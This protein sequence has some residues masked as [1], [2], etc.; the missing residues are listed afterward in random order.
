[1]GFQV[2][3]NGRG[4]VDSGVLAV[5]RAVNEYDE[6][7]YFD[8]NRDT[9][10]YCVYIKTPANEPDVPVIGFQEIP[11]P[12]DALKR[13]YHAD[14]LRHGE[15]ILEGMRRRNEAA[16]KEA[17]RTADEASGQMAEG[18]EWAFRKQGAHP[19][20]RIFIPGDK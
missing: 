6:R 19:S 15:E 3:V 4:M 18:L 7:L 20:P 11:H 5:D 13:L 1:M 10:D 9:G 12:E 14:S 17:G 2:F 16:R 8:R